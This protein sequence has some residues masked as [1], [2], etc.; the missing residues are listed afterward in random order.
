MRR[1]LADIKP[2][3]LEEFLKEAG[4]DVDSKGQRE[5]E[6]CEA[7]IYSYCSEMARTDP[8]SIAEWLA[9]EP[10]RRRAWFLLGCVAKYSPE[11]AAEKAK[12][13]IADN[14]LRRMSYSIIFETAASEDPERAARLAETFDFQDDSMKSI[15]IKSIVVNADD[16]N[17]SPERLAEILAAFSEDTLSDHPE[18]VSAGMAGLSQR[19]ITEVLSVFPLDGTEW[20][21][22][23]AVEFLE[24]K[25]YQGAKGDV[26]IREFL[27]F[28]QTKLLTP[29]ERGRLQAILGDSGDGEH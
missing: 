20:K 6:A 27:A 21:R 13:S 9:D 22:N 16:G 17:A 2:D 4:W 3:E 29:E 12:D 23:L 1:L 14:M 28:D 24:Q 7:I 5:K 15:A 11:L 25:A 10:E 19:P 18:A 8:E 26:E